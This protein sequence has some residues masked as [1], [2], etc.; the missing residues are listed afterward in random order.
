MIKGLVVAGHIC[1][2]Q[3][4]I[5]GC[6]PRAPLPVRPARVWGSTHRDR[7]ARPRTGPRRR[8]I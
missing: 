5:G 2:G 1:A 4:A 6:P 3:A 7:R 8:N